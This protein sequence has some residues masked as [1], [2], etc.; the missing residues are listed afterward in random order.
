MYYLNTV[1]KHGVAIFI[2]ISSVPVL[3]AASYVNGASNLTNYVPC[4]YGNGCVLVSFVTLQKKNRRYFWYYPSII[5]F[6]LTI[7]L[8][9]E[10]LVFV[11]YLLLKMV[12]FYAFLPDF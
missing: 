3:C 10:F 12:S 7:F 6:L 4:H 9:C 11:T 5:V 2:S 8:T 1:F